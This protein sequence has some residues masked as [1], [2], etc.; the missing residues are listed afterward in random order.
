M[1]KLTLIVL[2]C[3]LFVAGCKKD[4]YPVEKIIGK[5]Q[6]VGGYDLQAGGVY[7]VNIENQRIE[8]YTRDHQRIVYDYQGNE[9]SRCNFRTTE[10]VATIYGVETDGTQWDSSY[11]YWITNDT[12]KIRNSGG[13]EF[14]DEFFVRIE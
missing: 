10:S 6:L 13:F 3:V 8:K 9:I 5:W 12:L 11:E 14:Y 1:K 2:L 7:S 4:N